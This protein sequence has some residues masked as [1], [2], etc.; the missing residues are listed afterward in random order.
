MRTFEL[1][2]YLFIYFVGGISLTFD[3]NIGF[4]F[5][6]FLLVL[7]ILAAQMTK[8][9]L[10]ALPMSKD[11]DIQEVMIG[12]DLLSLTSN[13]LIQVLCCIL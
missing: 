10:H 1:P 3:L 13:V 7:H 5:S 9:Y 11:Q 8:A 4:L 12:E 6:L 2:F